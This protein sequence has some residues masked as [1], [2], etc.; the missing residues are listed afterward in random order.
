METEGDNLTL[1]RLEDSQTLQFGAERKVVGLGRSVAGNDVVC[2]SPLV[3]S[4]HLN[5]IRTTIGWI[6]LDLGSSRGTWVNSVKLRANQVH[7]LLGNDVITLGTAEQSSLAYQVISPDQTYDEGDPSEDFLDDFYSGISKEE[8]VFDVAE[9]KFDPSEEF[10]REELEEQTAKLR[11]RECYVKVKKLGTR[12]LACDH[13]DFSSVSQDHLAQ[14]IQSEHILVTY[15]CDTT[16]CDWSTEDKED[17]DRHKL[18]CHPSS[19]EKTRA[20]E[21]RAGGKPCVPCTE[22]DSVFRSKYSLLYH[23]QKIHVGRADFHC[24]ECGK[25]Y[26]MIYD[27][28]KHMRKCHGIELKSK[29]K[30][31]KI[32]DFTA[33]T[34]GEISR[35]SRLAHAGYECEICEKKLMSEYSLAKHKAS[36]HE[37][38]KMLSCEHEGCS[39]RTMYQ[40]DLRRHKDS[41]HDFSTKYD[42]SQCD[43]S[44]TSLPNFN[45]HV[46]KHA[47]TKFYCDKCTYVT[48]VRNYLTKHLKVTHSTLEFPCDKCDYKASNQL[49][50]KKHNASM[51]QERKYICETCGAKFPVNG[52]LTRHIRDVHNE[53]LLMCEFCDYKTLKQ[54]TLRIHRETKHL[55]TRYN[56]D[57]CD[58]SAA[59]KSR[60]RVHKQ[61]VHDKKRYPCQLCDYVAERKL[62]LDYHMRSQK[63]G[64]PGQTWF[65]KGK[66]Y[67]RRKKNNKMEETTDHG[68]DSEEQ[69]EEGMF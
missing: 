35:H 63:H 6:V 23:K 27:L 40:T 56:C 22:C 17:L 31:C 19:E 52:F 11:L 68:G 10:V 36:V 15:Y 65:Y 26:Y 9:E 39:F 58:F 32:C 37:R 5:F 64:G 8:E 3:S 7:W 18:G 46:A 50:L 14:H 61:V 51:H 12:L 1:Q 42:C 29:P 60:V 38:K 47:T 66:S 41:L 55:G 33:R 21:E 69:R 59:R 4:F 44:S 48:N 34:L 2:E 57:Q 28:K 20:E 24:E 53:T 13:C 43:Y 16:G 62:Y 25:S 54:V 30:K 67:K 49:S 45:N